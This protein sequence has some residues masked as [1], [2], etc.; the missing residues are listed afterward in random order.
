MMP[1]SILKMPSVNFVNILSNL[2][3]APHNKSQFPIW[4]RPYGQQTL[5]NVGPPSVWHYLMSV[6]PRVNVKLAFKISEI[7]PSPFSF[8]FVQ[9]LPPK[10]NYD[11]KLIRASSSTHF[12]PSCYG[13]ARLSMNFEDRQILIL[14]V[15]TRTKNI[16]NPKIT[17][18][19]IIFLML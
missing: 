2:T 3:S 11:T 13:G 9:N 12:T 10:C 8:S 16:L 14:N 18:L 15:S 4:C 1:I 7:A 17:I 6:G 5:N 19:F